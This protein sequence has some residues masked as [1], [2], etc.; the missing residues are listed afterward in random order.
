MV[1]FVQLFPE[2]S[3]R[4]AFD[5]SFTR[6]PGETPGLGNGKQP[7]SRQRAGLS[8]ALWVPPFPGATCSQVPPRGGGASCSHP[9]S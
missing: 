6:G 4:S 9:M 8:G 1:V 3:E 2:P 7:P 5:S